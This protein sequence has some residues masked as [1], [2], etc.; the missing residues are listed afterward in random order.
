MR[1]VP[2]TAGVILL[3]VG[4]CGG[5]SEAP[6]QEPEAPPREPSTPDTGDE[7]AAA[8][9]CDAFCTRARDC[10]GEGCDCPAHGRRLGLLKRSYLGQLAL[11]LDGVA[12]AAVQSGQAW[13]GCHDFVVKTIPSSDALRDFCFASSRRAADCG[14]G[15]DADQ[16]ACLIEYRHITDEALA[17]AT[18]CLERSCAEAPACAAQWLRP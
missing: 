3:V 8:I 14:R 16:S 1:L 17:Q 2:A 15:E 11:C 12:C 9:V 18:R 6:P 7:G 13:A 10:G 5:G 4:A